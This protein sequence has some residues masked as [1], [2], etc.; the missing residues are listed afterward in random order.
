MKNRLTITDVA[1]HVGVTPRTIMRWEKSG[2]IRKPK[3]DW[4]GWR[5]YFEDD[6]HKIK[7]F[8]DT[9]YEYNEEGSV[10]PAMARKMLIAALAIGVLLSTS[11][12]Y[13]PLYA[14]S[15]Q[16]A[17]AAVTE[18]KTSVNINLADLPAV[19]TPEAAITESVKYTLGPD[20]IIEITVRR[21]PEFS[22]QYPINSEGK[23]EYK[24][25]G[26][27]IVAGLTKNQLKERLNRILSEYI[28][29][30]DIDV[31]IVAYLSKVFYVVGEVGRPGKFFM[32][33][34]T[35]TIREALIQAGLPTLGAAMRRCR[36][37]TPDDKGKQNFKDVNVY[38][39]LYE[40]NL[41]ENMEMKPGEVLY[42]PATMMAKIVHVISP[43]TSATSQTTTAATQTATAATMMTP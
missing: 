32:R 26:D 12:L 9:C 43:V 5:I 20:D 16:E 6:L 24:Y 29:D 8:F 10:V 38:T 3:R 40:G 28:I 7:E 23:I 11:I 39:L 4:R 36:L 19:E 30:P 42:I 17:K 27:I 31:R 13:S 37:I 14:A 22:G 15:K 33:G 34:D 21:H 41:K 18:T 1:K 25:I 2:K 35:T